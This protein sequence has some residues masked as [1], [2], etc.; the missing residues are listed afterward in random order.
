[1][2]KPTHSNETIP[3]DRLLNM[4]GDDIKDRVDPLFSTNQNWIA[5]NPRYQNVENPPFPIPLS[6]PKRLSEKV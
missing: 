6:S 3:F 5:A 2:K 1:M 4:I